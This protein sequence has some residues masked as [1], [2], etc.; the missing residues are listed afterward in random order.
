MELDEAYRLAEEA[1]GRLDYIDHRLATR[2]EDYTKVEGGW[3]APYADA[4]WSVDRDIVYMPLGTSNFLF[5]D[6]Q[7]KA[8]RPI[9]LEQAMK[10]LGLEYRA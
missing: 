10:L 6:E 4:R 3:V 1:L 7:T 8:A 9:G 2:K 5:V